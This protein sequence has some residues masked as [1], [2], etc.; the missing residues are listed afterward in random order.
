MVDPI[1]C[2]LRYLRDLEAV[3]PWRKEMSYGSFFQAAVEGYVKEGVR[4]ACSFVDETA[5]SQITR[6]PESKSD[7][8]FWADLAKSLFLKCYLPRYP[9]VSCITKSE[10]HVAADI[11][12]PSG[13]VVKLHGYLDA[14]FEK[15]PPGLGPVTGCW[16]FGE[17]KCRG[18]WNEQTIA[19][20][21]PWD[22]QTNIYTLLLFAERGEIPPA[23]WYQH[24]RRPGGFAYGGPRQGKN[25]TL[26][27]WGSRVIKTIEAD[28][29]DYH[30]FR[31]WHR[32]TRAGLERFLWG[33]LYPYLEHFLDWYDYMVDPNR[34]QRVNKYHWIRPYGVYDNFM[35]TFPE[36]YRNYRVTG[37]T[38]GLRKKH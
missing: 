7:I 35:T 31:F 26:Q 10:R 34:D 8:L 3:E 14:E 22:L 13:R 18:E 12:L 17:H 33:F 16:G 28:T 15:L 25:E 19:E 30:F 38:R 9:E 5:D 20:N 36:A 27:Q 32:P 2:E 24:C 1:A 4:S 11:S 29:S 23:V 6:N 37:S 21:I